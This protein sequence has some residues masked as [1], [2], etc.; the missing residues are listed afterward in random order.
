MGSCTNYICFMTSNEK[1][2]Y[3]KRSVAR[4]LIGLVCGFLKRVFAVSPSRL[5]F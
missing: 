1:D 3:H 5:V 4:D 2:S